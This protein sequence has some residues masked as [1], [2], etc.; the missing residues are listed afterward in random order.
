MLS[1]VRCLCAWKSFSNAVSP[2]L[3]DSTTSLSY[4]VSSAS[5]LWCS[6]V[7]SISSPI[8]LISRSDFSNSVSEGN[9][10][11]P[12]S[13]ALFAARYISRSIGSP[14]QRSSTGRRDCISTRM[15]TPS[16]CS[17]LPELNSRS[18]SRFSS[19]ISSASRI[20]CNSGTS[21]ANVGFSFSL[22]GA[23]STPNTDSSVMPPIA[24]SASPIFGGGTR[25]IA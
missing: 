23:S 17:F 18:S 14:S 10:P 13:T 8:S 1:S 2:I 5:A 21:G 9:T 15:A 24:W 19:W 6:P 22:I 16:G 7:Y 11:P 12:S 3:S 20:C 25:F 4:A